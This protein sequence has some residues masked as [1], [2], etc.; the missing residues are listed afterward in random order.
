MRTFVVRVLLAVLLVAAACESSGSDPADVA[1]VDGADGGDAGAAVDGPSWADGEAT[2]RDVPGDVST[3]EMGP[4]GPQLDWLIALLGGPAAAITEPE[5][6]AHFSPAFLAAVPPAELVAL[7]KEVATSEGPITVHTVTI[8]ASGARVAIVETRRDTYWRISLEAGAGG[9]G[10]IQGLLFQLA[11]EADPGV[12]DFAGLGSRLSAVAPKVGLLIARVESDACTMVH[13]LRANDVMP[14]GS[15]FKLYVLGALGAK[16]AAGEGSWN[17]IV[18]I[19]EDWKSLPSGILQNQPAGA[20]LSAEEVAAKMIAISDNTATDHL[21]HSLGR[22]RV[23]AIQQPMGHG[24][25]ALN[26][27][28]LTTRDLFALK[29]AATPAEVAAYLAAAPAERRRLLDEV[30]GPRPLV[31][32]LGIIAAWTAPRHVEELEWFATPNDMCRALAWLK[33]AGEAP[34]GGPLL[35]ILAQN[36]G[37]NVDRTTFSYAGFKGGSEPGVMVGNWLLRRAGDGVWMVVSLGL[38]DTT[39]A[40]DEN[41]ASYYLTAAVQLAGR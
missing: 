35:T 27:P 24:N 15:A 29:L 22:D 7:L 14:L 38:A 18:T 21:I 39:R 19:R 41:L 36:P 40:I 17:D 1:P 30:H 34:G 26:L 33:R 23:Q 3:A 16:V 28:F 20:Q 25:P 11:P 9:A 8:A 4:G 13:G 37:V 31:T 32:D 10:L 5:V 2:D 6:R 12:R